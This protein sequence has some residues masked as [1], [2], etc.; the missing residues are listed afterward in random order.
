[1]TKWLAV[2]VCLLAAVP[3]LAQ[4]PVVVPGEIRCP[5]CAASGQKPAAPGFD[6]SQIE[7][8]P[9]VIPAFMNG[10]TLRMR[11]VARVLRAAPLMLEMLDVSAQ[12]VD[13]A[14]KV[15]R[16]DQGNSADPEACGGTTS[17][18]CS[19]PYRL[20]IRAPTDPAA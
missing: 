16:D 20:P 9:A 2:W 18:S 3:V 8:V 11:I 15:V 6:A 12:M 13:R 4:P 5:D 17:R 10:Q 7:F 19:T 1:M 14:M